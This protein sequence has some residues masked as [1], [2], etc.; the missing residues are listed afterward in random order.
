MSLKHT[1]RT[2]VV[3]IKEMEVAWSLYNFFKIFIVHSIFIL[4]LVIFFIFF[5]VIKLKYSFR[6]KL[7]AAFLLISIIPIIALAVYN[8]E[9]VRER[10]KSAIFS[11]LSKRSEYL[12]NHIR[13]QIQKHPDRDFQTAFENAGKELG[14]VFTIYQNSEIIFSSRSEYYKNQLIPGKLNSDVYY[15][16]N[17]LSYRE[18]LTKESIN[19]YVYDAYYK[20]IDFAGQAFILGVNDAFNKI[21]L[22]Y[23]PVDADVFLF[24]VYSFAVIII[25]LLSTLFA[26]QISS[27]IRQLTRATN[28]V[29]QGDL[30]VQL[31]NKE[32]GELKELLDGFNSMTNELQKNQYEI[33]ELERE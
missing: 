19:N 32:K 21:T 8:R 12:E 15:N 10:T 30:S 2:I 27:P 26:N 29:A 25:T 18:T 14:I 1:V 16:L 11:E 23:S 33:A 5:R 13:A 31:A 7:L 9:V 28:A 4:I 17:Y 22:F 3:S 20:K 24:G 6:T